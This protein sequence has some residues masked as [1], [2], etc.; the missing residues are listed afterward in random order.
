MVV[1]TAARS[2]LR[3]SSLCRAACR[4]ASRSKPSVLTFRSPLPNPLSH[5]IFRYVCGYVSLC[6][7]RCWEFLLYV[8]VIKSYVYTYE[9]AQWNW[10][11]AWSQC[12]RTTL[13]QLRLWWF[14]SSVDLTAAMGGF[15]KICDSWDIKGKIDFKRLRM[16]LQVR[17]VFKL[18]SCG[19]ESGNS[20]NFIFWL[21]DIMCFEKEKKL[22]IK[23]K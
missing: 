17:N 19:R 18:E 16:I 8:I 11:R 12:S 4:L 1:A 22:V 10:V 7:S 23:S 5:R 9:G 6:L 21:P 2:Y 15:L 14:R 20:G 3:S 13:L